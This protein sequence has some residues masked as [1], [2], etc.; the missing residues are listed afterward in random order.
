V[1]QSGRGESQPF[2]LFQPL[3]RM[4]PWGRGGAA[5]P[6]LKLAPDTQWGRHGDALWALALQSES[7]AVFFSA[8]DS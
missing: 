3:A 5:G 1:D 6:G 2:A 7:F 4:L 8:P